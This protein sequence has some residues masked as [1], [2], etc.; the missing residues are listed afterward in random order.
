MF[1]KFLKPISNS[2]LELC[3]FDIVLGVSEQDRI[4]T[5]FSGTFFQ[6]KFAMCLNINHISHVRGESN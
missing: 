3:G 5:L 6:Q 1:L 4:R 2:N